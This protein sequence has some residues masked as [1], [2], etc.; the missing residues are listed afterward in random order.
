MN[1]AGGDYVRDLT[2]CQRN[3]VREGGLSSLVVGFWVRDWTRNGYGITNPGSAMV[4]GG[5]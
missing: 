3:R 1:P 5:I 4:S 2:T